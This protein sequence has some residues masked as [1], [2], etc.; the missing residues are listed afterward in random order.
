[1]R[2]AQEKMAVVPGC[3]SRSWL[4]LS[5]REQFRTDFDSGDPGEDASIWVAMHVCV[6][7]SIFGK[8]SSE[9]SRRGRC[10]VTPCDFDIRLESCR[11][12]NM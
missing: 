9:Y 8:I 7:F 1:M 6:C 11:G 12:G 4:A 2:V 10:E 5:G 3:L